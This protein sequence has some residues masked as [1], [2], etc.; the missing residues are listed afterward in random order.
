M[1]SANEAT[2]HGNPLRLKSQQLPDYSISVRFGAVMFCRV[3][4]FRPA[5]IDITL[6]RLSV[7]VRSEVA[8]DSARA[9]EEGA[10]WLR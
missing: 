3:A 8:S 6:C 7:D 2:T 1:I 10:P 5:F 4:F 9:A